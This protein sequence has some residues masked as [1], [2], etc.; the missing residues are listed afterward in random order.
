MCHQPLSEIAVFATRRAVDELV[1]HDELARR[2][3]LAQRTDRADRQH[4]GY[5]AALQNVDIRARVDAFGRDGMPS[6]VPRQK[7]QFDPADTPQRDRAGGRAKGRGYLDNLRVFQQRK[8]VDARTA[9][10]ADAP[11]SLFCRVQ[12]DPP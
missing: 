3:L 11:V 10:D 9:D 5:A 1:D 12:G 8:I 6:A 7:R 4:I 2:H